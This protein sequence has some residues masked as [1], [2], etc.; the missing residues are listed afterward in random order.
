[1]KKFL[2]RN[3]ANFSS[4]KPRKCTQCRFFTSYW[5]A[6]RVEHAE[7]QVSHHSSPTDRYLGKREKERKGDFILTVWGERVNEIAH[8]K[9]GPIWHHSLPHPN[10][11]PR[12]VSFPPPARWALVSGN[13]RQAQVSF[14]LYFSCL[15][16][17]LSRDRLAILRF[18]FLFQLNDLQTPLGKVE[19]KQIT[20][21]SRNEQETVVFWLVINFGKGKQ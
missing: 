2:L 18:V 5:Y 6:G 15:E 10:V 7:L 11:N 4:R 12:V 21:K 1:M 9:Q 17:F 19:V 20:K 13:D 16:P 3:E 14:L 8:G